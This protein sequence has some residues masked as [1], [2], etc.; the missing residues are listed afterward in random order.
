MCIRDSATPI[1]LYNGIDGALVASVMAIFT[2]GV[3]LIYGSQEVG[4]PTKIVFPFT[5]TKINWSLNP[6]LKEEYK[7]IL[8]FRA[9]SDA[10]KRGVLTTFST[11]D[12]CA[13]TKERD[14]KKVFIMANVR[15]KSVD[16]TIPVGLVDQTAKDVVNG[17][18]KTFGT[19]ITFCLLYTS[20]SPRDR[21]RS[22][23]PS[24]A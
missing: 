19:K 22:R 1:K 14:G 12:V 24:S 13:F 9:G 6:A 16:L 4:F 10:I 20:P 2:G 23:M 15:N 8:K 17:G 5:G 3:P 18:T 11:T 21:T 7:K